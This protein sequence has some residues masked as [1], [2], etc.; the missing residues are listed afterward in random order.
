[1]LRLSDEHYFRAQLFEPAAVGIEIALE[2]EDSDFH[3]YR[4]SIISRRWSFVV[5]RW[6]KND[7]S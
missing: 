7:V 3:G 6:P 2:S 5:R 4:W 1:L